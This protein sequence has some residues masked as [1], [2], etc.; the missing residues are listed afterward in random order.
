MIFFLWG[1]NG[2]GHSTGKGC[3]GKGGNERNGAIAKRNGTTKYRC[4]KIMSVKCSSGVKLRNAVKGYAWIAEAYGT[5]TVKWSVRDV[6]QRGTNRTKPWNV[7]KRRKIHRSQV[8]ANK[9]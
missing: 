9:K 1:D 3:K 6:V 4:E 8:M 7:M 5:F 2:A